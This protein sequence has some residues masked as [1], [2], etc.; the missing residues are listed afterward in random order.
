VH[1]K[2]HDTTGQRDDRASPITN[3]TEVFEDKVFDAVRNIHGRS[4]VTHEAAVLFPSESCSNAFLNHGYKW[5]SWIHCSLNEPEFAQQHFEYFT[6]SQER[7]T[8]PTDPLW[9]AIYFSYLSVS[10]ELRSAF[11]ITK[12][13]FYRLAC[14]LWITLRHKL[15][16]YLTVRNILFCSILF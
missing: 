4:S 7:S 16:S 2:A 15:M 11:E 13:I 6:G 1:R 5:I 3:I 14:C 10:I 9:L 8:N 12:N